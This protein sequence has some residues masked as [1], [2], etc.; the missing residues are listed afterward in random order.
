MQ[1]LN[2]THNL[3][4]GFF[5]R[6]ITTEI[7]EE[8]KGTGL[9]SLWEVES[10]RN[11][12]HST[13]LLA[14][15]AKQ[16]EA[17]MGTVTADLTQVATDAT[18]EAAAATTT[19]VSTLGQQTEAVIAE[20]NPALATAAQ[21]LIAEAVSQATAKIAAAEPVII[22]VANSSIKIAISKLT[23]MYNKTSGSAQD[24]IA[25]ILGH[26]YASKS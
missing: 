15:E 1:G 21:P 2:C 20:V 7:P 24:E 10:F 19:E 11:D 5:P 25:V 8:L 9:E 22:S 17:K 12:Y 23:D 13:L 6:E 14:K 26:L 16:G 18:T 3:W 4:F